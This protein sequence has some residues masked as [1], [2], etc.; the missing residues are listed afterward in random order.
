MQ[1]FKPQNSTQYFLLPP[2][3]EDFI[4]QD[5]LARV[6]DEVVESIDTCDIENHYSCLGQ[7]SYHPKLLLKLLFY[8]Y[9]IGINQPCQECIVKD[10]FIAVKDQL[11][12]NKNE[13]IDSQYVQIK[14]LQN[15]IEQM[16][17]ETH[18]KQQTQYKRKDRK[19]E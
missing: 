10:N 5:H 8:G 3:I 17:Y 6:I 4:K 16:K 11:L 9:A 15:Q 19:S 13:L 7:K 14:L 18:E 2:S 1:K 12:Q